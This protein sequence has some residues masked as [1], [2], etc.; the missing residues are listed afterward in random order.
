MALMVS[1]T[2]QEFTEKLGAYRCPYCDAEHTFANEGGK[3]RLVATDTFEPHGRLTHCTNCNHELLRPTWSK[4]AHDG[5]VENAP[6]LQ[7]YHGLVCSRCEAICCFKCCKDVTRNRTDD[8][9]LLCPRCFRGPVNAFH[10]W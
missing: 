1:A 7:P 10:H 6:D 2:R 4:G 8:G 3:L 9:S 5:A